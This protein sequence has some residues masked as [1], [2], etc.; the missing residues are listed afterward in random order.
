VGWN[1]QID[2]QT[3]RQTDGWISAVLNIGKG[4]IATRYNRWIKMLYWLRWQSEERALESFLQETAT[5]MKFSWYCMTSQRRHFVCLRAL[6]AITILDAFLTCA[7]KPT[8]VSLFYRTETTTKTTTSHRA[9]GA[10]LYAC[11]L[12]IMINTNN[13][14][15]GFYTVSQKNKTPNSWP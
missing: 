15:T 5:W 7:R 14:I 10:R 4:I 12:L 8:C 13:I 3:D 2:R 6:L 11:S 9:R 1:R